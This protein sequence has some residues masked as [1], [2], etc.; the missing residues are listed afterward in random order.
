M[1]HAA[2]PK[3]HTAMAIPGK[4]AGQGHGPVWGGLED[5]VREAVPCALIQSPRC[6]GSFVANRNLGDPVGVDGN[7]LGYC[8]IK[9]PELAAVVVCEKVNG[10]PPVHPSAMDE[11]SQTGLK[12]IWCALENGCLSLTAFWTKP[13]HVIH[14]STKPS[15]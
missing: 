6:N 15:S 3:S 5:E 9:D 11:L 1:N 8:V 10:I 2:V 4:F 13:D 7:L 14:G 12:G